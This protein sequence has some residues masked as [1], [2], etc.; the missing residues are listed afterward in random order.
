MKR[1]AAQTKEKILSAA[2]ERFA[3]TGYEGATIR[4]IAA[5]MNGKVEPRSL[6]ELHAG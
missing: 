2:R 5:G 3:S 6:Q 1:S 4:A